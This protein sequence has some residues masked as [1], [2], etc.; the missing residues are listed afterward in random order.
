VVVRLHD[1]AAE[2]ERTYQHIEPEQFP[3]DDCGSSLRTA[4]P[5]R[6]SI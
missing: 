1:L 3:Y 6:S 4:M 5:E 2:I